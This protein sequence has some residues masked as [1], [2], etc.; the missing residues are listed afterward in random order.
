MEIELIEVML[1]DNGGK[2]LVGAKFISYSS[3][4]LRKQRTKYSLQNIE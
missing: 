2:T 4:F 1:Y 3:R